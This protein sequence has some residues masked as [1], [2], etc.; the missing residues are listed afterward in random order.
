MEDIMEKLNL[1]FTA[2]SV[3]EIEKARQLPIQNCMTD[4]SV[5]MLALFLQKGLV[6]ENG[7]VGVSRAVALSTIDN[8]LEESDTDNLLLDITEALV[9][10]GFLSRE[11]N[12][13]D[14]RTKR[15]KMLSQA[16]TTLNEI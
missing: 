6:D 12:V 3:D 15:E 4:N 16:M 1:K 11:L 2:Q 9:N 5:N 14:L 7:K 8:Y 10:A 13:A